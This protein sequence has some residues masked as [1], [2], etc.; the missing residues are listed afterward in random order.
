MR[1]APIDYFCLKRLCVSLDIR[2]WTRRLYA[3]RRAQLYCGC[4][5][6]AAKKLGQPPWSLLPPFAERVYESDE[7]LMSWACVRIFFRMY[8]HSLIDVC[9]SEKNKFISEA[10]QYIWHYWGIRYIHEKGERCARRIIS[11]TWPT[12]YHQQVCTCTHEKENLPDKASRDIKRC[13]RHKWSTR[14]F[15]SSASV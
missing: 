11:F 9:V 8:T 6:S 13:S 5:C 4:W 1:G 7:S 12:I 2:L 14:R 10:S 15:V 3:L